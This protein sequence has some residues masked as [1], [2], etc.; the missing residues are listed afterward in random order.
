MGERE[1]ELETEASSG[2]QQE[3]LR[4]ER[5]RTQ[6]GKR[7]EGLFSSRTGEIV[8]IV[9]CFG[10]WVRRCRV[11][12]SLVFRT[13]VDG[14]RNYTLGTH[15]STSTPPSYM[16]ET[17]FANTVVLSAPVPQQQHNAS[18]NDR[19]LSCATRRRFRREGRRCT[20]GWRAPSL[21]CPRL[22]S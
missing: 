18:L 6:R 10:P 1:S 12:Y 16:L 4:C 14:K 8:C 13:N 11:D 2:G 7:K 22:T 20:T 15:C 21:S 3:A 9:G 17:C 5:P 19:N